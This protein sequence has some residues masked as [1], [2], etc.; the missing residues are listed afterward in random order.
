MM[1]LFSRRNN[2]Y[3][4]IDTEMGFA[5][6][7]SQTDNVITQTLEGVNLRTVDLQTYRS[8][9]GS[10]HV[11]WSIYKMSVLRLSRR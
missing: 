9:S 7:C 6:T 8:C 10:C 11:R 4:K 3:E 2:F 1:D 5:A